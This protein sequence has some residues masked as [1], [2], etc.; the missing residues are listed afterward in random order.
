MIELIEIALH[1]QIELVKFMIAL[2]TLFIAAVEDFRT[3]YIHDI[4]WIIPLVS[5]LI[6]NPIEYVLYGDRIFL[7]LF[8]ASMAL[9][10]AIALILKIS[11]K[12]GSG[13]SL[14]IIS[15]GFLLPVRPSTPFTICSSGIVY[16]VFLA[17][18]LDNMVFIA[19]FYTF[20]NL[21]A[22][23]RWYIK[24][25]SLFENLDEPTYKKV[26]LLFL[27]QRAFK[28]G[29]QRLCPIEFKQENGKIKTRLLHFTGEVSYNVRK[30]MWCVY[31]APTLVFM[32][33][34]FLTA[35]LFGDFILM[36][37]AKI[38]EVIML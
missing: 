30:G 2:T 16:P 25:G 1:P 7:I 36:I 20:V 29:F 18:I 27:A 9:S 28:D 21:A 35:S 32:F 26:A 17:S 13:D 11:G 3:R 23:I 10:L 14:M 6:L 37:A 34:G 5:G 8:L 31:L 38:V 22:N 19:V 24:H 4:L 33:L 12:F 15:L